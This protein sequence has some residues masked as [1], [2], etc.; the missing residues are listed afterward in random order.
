M[1]VAIVSFL[2]EKQKLKELKEF[3]KGHRLVFR[4]PE[5]IVVYGGDGT[6]LAAEEKFPG[7]KKL[8]FYKNCRKF[9]FFDNYKNYIKLDVFLN[10]KK[11]FTALNDVNVHYKLPR[12]LR[13]NIKVNHFDLGENL[14]GDGVI[15]A[16]PFGANAYY[17]TITGNS[18]TK[19]IGIAFNNV[20]GN[21]T[22]KVVDE[23]SVV[24][25]IINRE[26]GFLAVDSNSKV[27]E[28]KKGDS[29]V[30]KKSKEIACVSR[31]E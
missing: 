25:I 22:N 17:R 8:F 6:L 30:I 16:T 5:L 28:L 18:F 15:V 9:D 26:E 24:E 10:G 4:K 3:L 19:G 11:L 27:F 2:K 20:I 1:R 23:N 12:A 29:V 13:F 21:K 7:V 31:R 14:I